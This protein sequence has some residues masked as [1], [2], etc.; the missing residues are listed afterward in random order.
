MN[1]EGRKQME[2]LEQTINLFK[3]KVAAKDSLI[4]EQK[5]AIQALERHIE[6]LS[7]LL[8]KILKP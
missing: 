7:G 8:D 6:E 2:L 3:Q 5:K 4:R 1:Q